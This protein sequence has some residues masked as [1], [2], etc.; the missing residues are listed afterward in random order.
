[1]TSFKPQT[2]YDPRF[3]VITHSRG[4]P[5]PICTHALGCGH[6]CDDTL[7]ICHPCWL[8]CP[9][10]PTL[11]WWDSNDPDAPLGQGG[12]EP[13]EACTTSTY[14]SCSTHCVIATGASTTATQTC[15]TTC[16][17]I[18][19]CETEGTDD[20]TYITLSCP[21]LPSYT[22][23]WADG[24]Q[25]APVLG[26]G[27]YGGQVVYGT[28]TTPANT[29]RTTITSTNQKSATTSPSPIIPPPSRTSRP[30]ST[31][32]LASSTTTRGASS[33]VS[34][35]STSSRAPT[36]TQVVSVFTTTVDSRV[37]DFLVNARQF[38]ENADHQIATIDQYNLNYKGLTQTISVCTAGF[39]Y[40]YG[41]AKPGVKTWSQVPQSVSFYSTMNNADLNSPGAYYQY[42]Q[43]EQGCQPPWGYLA[44]SRNGLPGYRC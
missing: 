20:S 34:R 35:P 27:G 24:S 38:K 25:L 39:Y 43:D 26:D 36:S 13:D 30:S 41:A 9:G 7:N 21:A 6:H 22:P 28:M 31:S 33:T 14:P 23:F 1:M 40:V 8:S 44:S 10:P 4:P 3:P 19:G 5:S 11:N 2:S 15:S 37:G 42:N 18:V 29:Q 17:N 32:T 16:R 12:G